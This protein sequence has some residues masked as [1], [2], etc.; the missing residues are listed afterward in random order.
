MKFW[1]AISDFIYLSNFYLIVPFYL[2]GI[3]FKRWALM[4]KKS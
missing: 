4:G 3:D 1:V 2:R